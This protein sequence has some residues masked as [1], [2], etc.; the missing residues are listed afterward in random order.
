MSQDDLSVFHEKMRAQN[1]GGPHRL[2]LPGL[3]IISISIA[4]WF[5]VRWWTA[6]I[7]LDAAM[8]ELKANKMELNDL[9]Q[10]LEAQRLINK[11][12][13]EMLKTAMESPKV[14]ASLWEDAWR[15]KTWN[16][17]QPWAAGSVGP[18]WSSNPEFVDSSA[19]PRTL[20]VVRRTC[21]NRS[22]W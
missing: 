8:M 19:S 10:N 9:R 21:R 15:P 22:I 4:G 6:R 3:L 14:G 2:I 20:P 12:Q 1:L 11:R 17:S 7:E 5:G 13:A 16:L 18:L